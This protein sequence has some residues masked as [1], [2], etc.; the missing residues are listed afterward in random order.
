MRPASSDGSDDD[1]EDDDQAGKEHGSMHQ[2][3]G[4][5]WQAG[6]QGSFWDFSHRR[7]ALSRGDALLVHACELR[8]EISLTAALTAH[9][10]EFNKLQLYV[11]SEGSSCQVS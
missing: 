3:T 5:Q 9:A 7:P 8:L 10:A 1:G 6:S 2:D 4:A 11:S